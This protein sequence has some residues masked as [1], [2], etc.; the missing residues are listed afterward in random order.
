[1]A[2]NKYTKI[3]HFDIDLSKPNQK[4]IFFDNTSTVIGYLFVD[5]NKQISSKIRIKDKEYSFT[6]GDFEENIKQNC[7]IVSFR[8]DTFIFIE[9]INIIY[10]VIFKYNNGKHF[11]G[12]KFIKYECFMDR[13]YTY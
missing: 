9:P 7:I 11:F 6:H 12:S 2:S 5:K 3:A 4:F 8:D 13:D 1:M 10:K